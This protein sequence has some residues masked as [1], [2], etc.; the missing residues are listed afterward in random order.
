MIVFY[1][2]KVFL[3]MKENNI[4]DISWLLLIKNGPRFSKPGAVAV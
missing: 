4:R 2:E 1:H 3:A